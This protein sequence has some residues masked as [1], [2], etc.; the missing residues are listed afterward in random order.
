VI[1]DLEKKWLGRAWCAGRP[2]NSFFVDHGVV[3]YQRP[4]QKTQAAWD[5]A[6][7]VCFIC[8][9]QRECARDFLGEV[10][11][12]FGGLDP[13]QRMRLRRKHGQRVR[14]LEGA[15]KEEY[16]KLAYSLMKTYK[17]I[18][19]V[20]RV[21]GLPTTVVQYLYDWWKEHLA[22][23]QSAKASKP[24]PID[25]VPARKAA[26][27]TAAPTKGE[28]WVRHAGTVVH[29]Y[30]LGQTEDDAWFF[31]KVPL[32]KE[33]SCAWFKAEDVQFRRPITRNVRRRTGKTSRIYGTPISNT[34]SPSRQAG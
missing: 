11:G 10:D 5:N 30:Y 21:M 27:P 14:N 13:V 19:P 3:Q 8:P 15:R 34:Q 18:S 28:A 6:K 17:L 25:T 33:D 4:T 32:S 22:E 12:V 2:V 1:V 24:L 9:V 20:A 23:Q 29:G 26:W 31:M 7:R 16:A